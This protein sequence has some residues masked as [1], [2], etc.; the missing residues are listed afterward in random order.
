MELL[1]ALLITL[2]EEKIDNPEYRRW[3]SCA[4]GSWVTT[5]SDMT[6]NGVRSVSDITKTLKEVGKDFLMIEETHT[7]NTGGTLVLGEP[8]K[9]KILARVP[10]SWAPEKITREGSEEIE[11][12]G[13]KLV[14]RWEQRGSEPFSRIWLS[15]EIPGG[16]AKSVF[17]VNGVP[18]ISRVVT[19]WERKK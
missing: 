18:T 10:I 17:T 6:L 5:K 13:K 1:F 2:Q 16:I 19:K 9:T 11:I 3:A 4:A 14:C 15:D 8:T 12:D 7:I